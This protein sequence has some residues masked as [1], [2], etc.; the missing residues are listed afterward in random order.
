V[1]KRRRVVVAS[2]VVAAALVAG[3][4]WWYLRDDAP[5]PVDLQDAVASLDD[6]GDRTDAAG[7]GGIEGDWVVDEN[8][9]EVDLD[10]ARGSFVGFRIREQLAGIGAAT[11]VGRTA[12][13]QGTVTI[14]GTTLTAA[15]VEV[16]MTRISTNDPRR[17]SRVSGALEVGRF[18]TATFELTSPVELGDGAAD[19]EPISVRAAGDLTIHGVSRSVV[20][21]L[22]AQLVDGTVVVVGSIDVVFAD[23]D[24]EVPD[25]QIV[26]SVEDHGE[27]ELQLVLTKR[28]AG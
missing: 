6:G 1:R 7:A 4:V 26:L 11:A 8:G 19:G 20:F 28:T 14:E 9:G 22:E 2:V 5:P 3:G 16:D 24:V 25:S 23:Y 27:L 21:P 15:K 13:V 18:P 17:D 10:E 12:D